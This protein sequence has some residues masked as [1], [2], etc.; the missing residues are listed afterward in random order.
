M[1]ARDGLPANFARPGVPGRPS[2]HDGLDRLLGPRILRHLA[3]AQE[4]EHRRHHQHEDE[5]DQ[6]RRPAPQ[7]G[8]GSSAGKKNMKNVE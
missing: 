1:R 7:P 8:V 5:H 4:R 6:E 2:S 3:V